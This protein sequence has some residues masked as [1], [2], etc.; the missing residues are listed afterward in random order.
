[1]A[2]SLEPVRKG[3]KSKGRDLLPGLSAGDVGAAEAAAELLRTQ[4]NPHVGS[5]MG[6]PIRSKDYLK[7]F[8]FHFGYFITQPFLA[9]EPYWG[10][11]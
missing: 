4:K 3:Q 7:I 8:F 9:E 6:P 2:C 1:M 5:V 11:A 10:K